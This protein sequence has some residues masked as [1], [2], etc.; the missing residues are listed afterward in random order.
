MLYKLFYSFRRDDKSLVKFKI[1]ECSS[2]P[3]LDAKY[4]TRGIKISNDITIYV[5]ERFVLSKCHV[6]IITW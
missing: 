6:F 4:N 5:K 3:R 2:L 1:V